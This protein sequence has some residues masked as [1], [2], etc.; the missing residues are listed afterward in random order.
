MRPSSSARKRLEAIRVRRRRA[1]STPP[2]RFP[3]AAVALPPQL[4][5]SPPPFV[6]STPSSPTARPLPH[7]VK[8]PEPAVRA[9]PR[10]HYRF[11]HDVLAEDDARIS[12]VTADPHLPRRPGPSPSRR[13]ASQAPAA[14]VAASPAELGGEGGWAS[15]PTEVG[16][17]K[18]PAAALFCLPG[19]ETREAKPSCRFTYFCYFAKQASKQATAAANPSAAAGPGGS[20]LFKL[21]SSS[22]GP[23][24]RLLQRW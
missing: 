14:R 9:P 13:V 5:S 15:A 17:P 24:L 21:T 2:S 23:A 7:R 6:T 22:T 19:D 3:H 20:S 4:P 8:P 10:C 11:L 16:A 12:P 1:S 18:A